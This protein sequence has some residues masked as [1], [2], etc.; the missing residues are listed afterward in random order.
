MNLKTYK[1]L[2]I[3]WSIVILTLTSI[4]K[5]KTPVDEPFNIDKIAHFV[6]YIIFAYLFIKMHLKKNLIKTL[7]VLWILAI[8]VPIFDELHQIPIPGRQFSFWDI[9]ADFLG[10]LA[11]L[12]FFTYRKKPKT[13][14]NK[15]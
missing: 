12:L 9:I 8:I 6:V 15:S 14:R 4:P 7:K 1:I 13:R 5:L 2:F 11:I 3:L 10:F